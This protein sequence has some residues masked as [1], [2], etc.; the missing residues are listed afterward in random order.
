MV[1]G[2]NLIDWFYNF[3][4]STFPLYDIIF[5]HLINFQSNIRASGKFLKTNSIIFKLYYNEA[6]HHVDGIFFIIFFNPKS[7]VV[8]YLL[9]KAVNILH[10]TVYYSIKN[11][12]GYSYFRILIVKFQLLSQLMQHYWLLRFLY[13]IVWIQ[14]AG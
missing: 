8:F 9:F 4:P 11:R 5:F 1:F 13:T 14:F 12:S 6:F 7:N 3:C 10:A 2:Q